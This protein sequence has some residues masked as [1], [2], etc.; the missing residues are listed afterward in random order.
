MATMVSRD[1]QRIPGVGP[2]TAQV[3]IDLGI[4]SCTISSA[5]RKGCTSTGAYSTCS[6][7]RCTSPRP[8][9]RIQNY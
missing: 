3:L 6:D 7:V 5:P 8:L 9:S 2:R 1:L 4:S